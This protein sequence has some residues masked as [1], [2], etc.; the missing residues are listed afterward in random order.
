[1]TE[2]KAQFIDRTGYTTPPLE[3]WEPVLISKEQIDDEV[4]RLGAL[5][6]PDN[7]RRQSLVVHPDWQKLGVGPGLNPGIRVTLEVLNPGEQSA[8]IRHNSTQVNFCIQGAGHSIVNG[9][10][11]EFGLHDVFNFPS[12]ATYWHSRVSARISRVAFGG[13]R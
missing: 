13:I 9:K 1:M 2:N 8:P 11:I 3:L 10:R 4:A 12:M 6:R 7:G 5:P